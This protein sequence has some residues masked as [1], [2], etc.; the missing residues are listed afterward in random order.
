MALIRGIECPHVNELI[1]TRGRDF[2]HDEA[3]DAGFPIPRSITSNGLGHVFECFATIPVIKIKELVVQ[4][5]TLEVR[6]ELEVRTCV[7]RP[8]DT[9][10][11]SATLFI[12]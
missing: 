8:V 3:S 11:R 7:I 1:D 12:F 10:L 6:R 9:V 4:Q 2:R 5:V